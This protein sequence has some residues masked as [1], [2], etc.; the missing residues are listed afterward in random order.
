ML[1]VSSKMPPQE[2]ALGDFQFGKCIG[3]G[4]YSKVYRA[5]SK[6][7]NRTFAVKVISKAH[8][9]RE[10][11]QK[12][13]NI[14]KDTLSV[15]GSHPGVVAL[16]YTFQD[17]KSLY[18]VID[19]AEHGELL[20]LIRRLGTLSEPLTR[21]YMIQLIDSLSFVHSKGIIHRDLKPENILLSHDWKLMLTD[22]GAAKI[23]NKT[24][25]QTFDA[26]TNS[27]IDT[28]NGPYVNKGGSFVGTAEYVSP[29]LLK[30]NISDYSG[31]IWALGCIAYQM[32]VGHPPF[33]GSDEYDTFDKIVN[34]QYGYPS[35]YFIPV[36]IRD[37]IQ[38][39]L[40]LKP[41]DRYTLDD[42][43][44]H[45]WFCDVNWG[46][47]DSIWRRPTPRL[48][49]Y[50]PKVYELN[51]RLRHSP[52]RPKRL[53]PDQLLS[54]PGFYSDL[55]GMDGLPMS[56]PKGA[57]RVQAK[58]RKKFGQQ[59]A[60]VKVPI[61]GGAQTAS[62]DAYN[63]P[64][65]VPRI[66]TNI[67]RSAQSASVR[68]LAQPRYRGRGAT[69]TPATPVYKSAGVVSPVEEPHSAQASY[70]DKEI[71]RPNNDPE[72]SFLPRNPCNKH[73]KHL[74]IPAKDEVYRSLGNNYS[75]GNQKARTM[76]S[77]DA[78]KAAGS[79][80]AAACSS[81]NCSKKSPV[82][83]DAARKFV[84]DGSSRI[85][86][87]SAIPKDISDKLTKD[88]S[89]IKLDK[90]FISR[91]VYEARR[92]A[93]KGKALDD[94]ILNKII[95]ENCQTLNEDI[96]ACILIITT[97]ARLFVYNIPGGKKCPDDYSQAVEIRLTSKNVSMYDYEFNEEL[98]EGYLILELMNSCTLFFLSTYN[99]DAGSDESEG[100]VL[101]FRV[102]PSLTWVQALMQARK[103]VKENK[104]TLQ[105]KDANNNSK[106]IGHHRHASSVSTK[107]DTYVNMRKNNQSERQAYGV[108]EGLKHMHIKSQQAF[109]K[110]A[111][112]AAGVV[113][114][115]H[116]K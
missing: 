111:L 87:K 89:I 54:V 38:H 12:Y 60:G 30:Y 20:S 40:V 22:F 1:I 55:G 16:Y 78:I 23:L 10:N 47:S 82:S 85:G 26:E 80:F 72:L 18:F 97:H 70:N 84:C 73:E 59:P 35:G 110:D 104:H 108:T 44:H 7:T 61:L 17:L 113:I 41:E 57:M 3:E 86:T 95:T 109:S 94:V 74:S 19:F 83:K 63:H 46:D 27:S 49:S 67:P 114:R 31:D 8:I 62:V 13:V 79:V 25:K 116:H 32:I 14:E 52:R 101:G 93:S 58:A 64:Q 76:A 21:Y 4:S 69:S 105:K 77:P 65:I 90:I 36:V 103:L 88:E 66:M 96:K 39:L 42:A 100:N 99:H 92:V 115:N 9:E 107:S 68:P 43:M 51:Y 45:K 53:T 24:D 102:N 48:D 112:A 98:K 106:R 50:N 91:L 81:Q 56:V 71:N 33:K 37:F 2:V 28:Y 75:G 29:E 5:I 11:K 6:K 34:L 15:L